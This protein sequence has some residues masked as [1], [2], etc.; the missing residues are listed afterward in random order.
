[1]ASNDII[2]LDQTLGQKK[3]QT[4][5]EL[6]DADFF[7][8]FS[9]EQILKKFD[10]SY[11]EISSGKVG[12]G[13]NG[14][15]DGFFTFISSELLDEDT[16]LSKVE[17][18]STIEV[19]LIQAKR[20]PTFSEVSI[21]RVNSTVSDIFNLANELIDFRSMYDAYLLSKAGIFR[22]AYL[23][24]A[25]RH[26]EVKV[27]Y[28]YSSRGDTSAIHRNVKHRGETLK[29]TINRWF[30][31]AQI[32][33]T[34]M[35]AREL[36]DVSRIESSYTLQ[37]RFL[38]NYIS[39][40]A[41]NYVVLANLPDYFKFVT[42]DTGNL[43]RH[44]F[45]AN[46]RDYQGNVEVNQDILQTLQSNDGMDFW[47]LNNGIT[48]LTSK[49]SVTGK[50]ITL[51]DVQIVNGLQ[52][53]IVVYNYLRQ[54]DIEEKDNR[55]SLL[56]RI[57]VTNSPEERDRI[58][59][60]TNFQT[61]IPVSSLKAT[62][63]VQRN[64]EEY[65]L[66]RDLYYDRRKNHYK[67]DGKPALKIVSIPY[68]A[69][70]VM[71]MVLR[72]PDNARARPSSI[73]KRATDYKR[74]FDESL[75]LDTYLFCAR[76]MKRIDSFIRNEETQYSMRDKSDLKFH[77]GMVLVI[78]LLTNADYKPRDVEVLHRIDIDNSH[79]KKVL[80]IVMNLAQSYSKDRDLPIERIAKSRE[81][82]EFLIGGIGA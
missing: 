36:L 59:K 24:L 45:E 62:D 17:K 23:E 22:K 51:D 49:A 55:R 20:S 3:Q 48:V 68:L 63:R 34:F 66:G 79:L 35:G 14:G 12:A 50:T 47:W 7:E 81:F 39:R 32:D 16:D 27:S 73:I 57:V 77:I 5:S 18:G 10:L 1:M 40:S 21:D 13:G 44:I 15:I 78:K 46:V 74:V 33:V 64:I 38:E 28:V 69:Q 8:L 2:L 56:I 82:V 72:E 31:S 60:A 54:K 37:L 11:D 76:T 71:A 61:A 70:S 58:I 53:S 65:F 19:F 6:S 75:G 67:N 29:E 43:R 30:P 4:S 25:A 80:T 52:T 9:F 42:D 26:P 41:N